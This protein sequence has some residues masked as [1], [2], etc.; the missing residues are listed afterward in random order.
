MIQHFSS[1]YVVVFEYDRLCACL[2]KKEC[3]FMHTCMRE[4][5]SIYL[6]ACERVCLAVWKSVDFI[7]VGIFVYVSEGVYQSVNY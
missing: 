6:C 1:F 4:G 3:K 2:V 5:N 7:R